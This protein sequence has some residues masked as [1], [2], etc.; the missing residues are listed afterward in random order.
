MSVILSIL[1]KKRCSDTQSGFRVIDL[2][3]MGA[4][5]VKAKR[6]D[7]ESEF[8]IRAAR[9]GMSIKEVNIR[10]I[11]N[12][13]PRSKIKVASETIRFISLVLRNII[14]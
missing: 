14:F 8:F 10:S 4:L 2:A 13:Q 11:Y 5:S 1:V 3:R 9:A 6:F 12:V 7:W